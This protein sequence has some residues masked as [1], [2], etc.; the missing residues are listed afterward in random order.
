MHPIEKVHKMIL[1]G[2]VLGPSGTWIPR[3]E[4]LKN[5]RYFLKHVFNGEIEHDGRWVRLSELTTKPDVVMSA[6]L[7]EELAVVP[8]ESGPVLKEKDTAILPG[9]PVVQ[10]HHEVD[11]FPVAAP[12]A[13]PPQT[14]LDRD[15]LPSI[16]QLRQQTPPV[17]DTP[18][19]VPQHPQHEDRTPDYRDLP[20]QPQ[21]IKAPESRPEETD[22]FQKETITI[23]SIPLGKDT[24]L[25]I[26]ESRAGSALVAICSIRGFLDQSNTDDFHAQLISM[27]D[28]GVRFFII[29]FEQTTLVGS[30]GWGILAVSARL[31]KAQQGHLLICAMKDEIEESFLLLQFNNVIDARKTITDCLGVIRDIIKNQKEREAPDGDTAASFSH[32]GESFDELPLPEKIKTIISRNGP[33]TFFKIADHLK[34]DQYGNVRI[35]LVKLYFILKELNLETHWKRVRYYRSC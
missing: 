11:F 23:R 7:P 15:T 27:L 2:K 19:P 13:P 34:Q 35:S 28:F 14:P 4:A 17:R 33:L 26:S 20:P 9:T 31:I 8:A 18:P 1:D 30:A 21:H 3:T 22:T 29:D 25:T 32:Y 24:T 12:T 5:K 10:K 6:D 16:P